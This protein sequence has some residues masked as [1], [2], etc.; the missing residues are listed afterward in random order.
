MTKLS[1]KALRFVAMAMRDMGPKEKAV[2]AKVGRAQLTKLS[3][4]AAEVALIAL[5]HYEKFVRQ[6]LAVA[7]DE[8]E[9]SDLSNDLGFICAIERDLAKGKRK[10]PG[11]IRRLAGRRAAS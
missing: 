6:R 9:V 1:P 7:R 5:G 2:W 10:R 4:E 3:V 11:L 8:D